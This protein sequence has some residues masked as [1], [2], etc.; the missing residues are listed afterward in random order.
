MRRQAIFLVAFGLLLAGTANAVEVQQ[1]A[2]V[3][4]LVIQPLP[5]APADRGSCDVGNPNEPTWNYGNWIMGGEVYAYLVR[6]SLEGC[7]CE[8]GF[9]LDQV[10]ML[11]QFG[12]EDAPVTFAA[13]VGLAEAVWNPQTGRWAPG[14]EYCQ[15]ATW[16]I[17]AGLP[18][19]YEIYVDLDGA[20]PCATMG[21]AYF[22]TFHLPNDFTWW[23]DALEDDAPQA[24]VC[25]Y[26]SGT[27]WRDLV[28]DLGW[29]GK[30]IM[31][32]S[33]SCCTD[34]VASEGRTW[35][36]VKSTYR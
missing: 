25:Y 6:P 11:M 19:L 9:V 2:T 14:Q 17:S 29:W 3:A 5:A 20:C 15:S 24:G 35:G 34:P 27:G 13:F 28:G 4:P 31:R 32:A 12:N 23:P 21:D 30:N 18:G 10:S 33:I 8:E 7:A 22:V 1:Q 16:S 36:H 26:D